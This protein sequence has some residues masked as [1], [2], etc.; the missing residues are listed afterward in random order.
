MEACEGSQ[1]RRKEGL[2]KERAKELKKA[3]GDRLR[4]LIQGE[5]SGRVHKLL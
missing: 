2:I 3:C 1:G 5:E 4:G